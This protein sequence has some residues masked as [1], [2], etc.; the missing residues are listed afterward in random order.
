MVGSAVNNISRA[1]NHVNL[2]ALYRD[3]ERGL[4]DFEQGVR[5]IHLPNTMSGIPGY[6][7]PTSVEDKYA[8]T[9]STDTTSE[10]Q[11][12]PDTATVLII[13]AGTFGT[14]TAYHL[15][16]R[17]EDPSR[18]T[19]VDR[20]PSPPK[21]AAS[22]DINRIIRP[23]YPNSL[24]CNLAWEAINSWFWLPELQGSFRQTG[25]IMIYDSKSLADETRQIFKERGYENTT[26][27]PVDGLAS[28]AKCRG[29]LEGT[30]TEGVEDAYWNPDAGWANAAKA[31]A[32]YMDEA[33]RYGVNRIVAEI[34]E[35]VVEDGHVK[36]VRTADGKV[37]T[38]D[39]IVL[40]SGAWTSSLL[41]PVEDALNMKDEHRIERQLRATGVVSAYY[42]V[43]PDEISQHKKAPVVMYGDRGQV[44]PA[45]EENEMIKYTNSQTMFVN[46]I[47][48]RS[49]RKIS[50]P[51]SDR[52]QHDVPNGLKRETDKM[53][54]SKVMPEFAKGKDA[55]HWRI[56]WDAR[57]PS[58][59]WLL[60]RHP[61]ERLGNVYLAVGGSFQAYK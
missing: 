16:K 34:E 44:I 22:I 38:A 29:A 56:C 15:A 46:T 6:Y 23:D 26:T 39:K 61:D 10:E 31:T 32:S 17:Y 37:L 55:D 52:S 51:P 36:G 53:I 40:A 7:R 4:L 54:V 58:Q 14:S 50:A 18:I 9:R 24:Y 25:G 30:S 2:P 21:P 12:M 45:S 28:H 59:H 43:S 19:V 5:T 33:K 3:P 41:S 35:L 8:S 48:T 49:G 42:K 20:A 27:I 11:D 47:T 13:G 1:D 60:C 57:T